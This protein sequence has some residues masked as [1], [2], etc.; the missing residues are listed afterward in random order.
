M[1]SLPLSAA[2]QQVLD[3]LSEGDVEGA[4]GLAKQLQQQLPQDRRTSRLLADVRLKSG[5]PDGAHAELARVTAAFPDERDG[6]EK[7]AEI[8]PEAAATVLADLPPLP[9]NNGSRPAISPAALG[10]LF[11]RQ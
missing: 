11:A 5:D 2:R 7:L 3:R 10:H 6:W 9:R 4:L 1:A 8:R